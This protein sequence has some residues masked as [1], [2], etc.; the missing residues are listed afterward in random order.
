MFQDKASFRNW[1]CQD[2]WAVFTWVSIQTI[3]SQEISTHVNID[4]DGPEFIKPWVII[5]LKTL[6]DHIT[7][8]STEKGIALKP[9][10]VK[11]KQLLEIKWWR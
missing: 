2:Y 3:L 8:D 10:R 5:L 9:G 11:S 1:L 7:L 6:D 4:K